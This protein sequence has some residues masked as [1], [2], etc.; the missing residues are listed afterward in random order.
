MHAV[1]SR[2]N[3]TGTIKQ[4]FDATRADPRYHRNTPKEIVEIAET[5]LQRALSAVKMAAMFSDVPDVPLVVVP[6]NTS[7]FPARYQLALVN[8]S[9]CG[10]FY[11]NV[12]KS[13]EV[14]VFILLI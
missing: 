6:Q 12:N 10:V 13:E 4:F 3:F 2:L 7:G 11:L 9:V 14:S 8:G 1:L 5:Y